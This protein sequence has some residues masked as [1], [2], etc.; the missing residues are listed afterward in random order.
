MSSRQ[1]RRSGMVWTAMLYRRLTFLL[2][3]LALTLPMRPAA[4]RAVVVYVE[5]SDLFR[6]RGR[7][8][9]L[10]R[11]A[12][13][14][15]ASRVYE[16]GLGMAR[17]RGDFRSSLRFLNN[18][19]SASFQLLR[20]R[21]AARTYLQA[22]GIAEAQ[23]D[24]E[25]LAAASF[26]LSSV[27]LQLG[28]VDAAREAAERG[29]GAPAGAASKFQSSLLIQL[30][31]ISAGEGDWSGAA[32]RLHQ[33]IAVARGQADSVAE[34]QAWNELGNVLL[35]CRRLPEAEDA[36]LESYRLR[37]LARDPRLH[38]SYEAL[39]ELRLAQNDPA[40]AARLLDR[41]IEIA[42]DLGPAALWRPLYSR[43]RARRALGRTEEAYDDLRNAVD[44]LRDWR[45]Q[46]LPA[47]AFR[48]RSEAESHR[49]YTAFIDAASERARQT[50]RGLYAREAF[51][52]AESGRAASLRALWTGTDRTRQ[53]SPDYW[54]VRAELRRA[55]SDDARN[56]AGADR[57]RGVRARL[58][59][60]EAEA[61]LSLAPTPEAAGDAGKLIEATRRALG[62]GEA[63]I[64]FHTGESRSAV[65]AV[66]RDTFAMADAPPEAELERSIGEF[67]DALRT[68]KPEARAAG[69]R[70]FAELFGKLGR[71]VLAMQ[72]WTVAPDG[73]LF[74]LPFA[75]L[76]DGD[77]YLIEG[78]ELRVTIG[79]AGLLRAPAA[80]GS[81]SFVGIGDPVYNRADARHPRRSAASAEG[82]SL[83]LPRLPGS[84]REV[85]SCAAL[86]R[87][88]GRPALLIEGADATREKL[89]RALAGRPAVAH[90]AA[91]MLF[92][93][94]GAVRGLLAL[95]LDPRHGVELLSDTEVAGM[96]ANV[97]LV[98]LNGCSS[99]R[100]AVLPGA[101]LMGMTRAW[102]AAGAH[103]VIATRWPA[104]DQ[105]ASSLFESLYRLYFERRER[106]TFGALLREAQL[107]ELR[108]GGRRAEP[109]RWASYFCLE[110]R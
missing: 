66:T 89:A 99:G 65:F 96:D 6:L 62:P 35:E 33:A 103:A 82:A 51:A 67:V 83:E 105:T 8:N 63:Y 11:A 81:D 44:N 20:Y 108:A 49:V 39:A 77:R 97:G 13:Y 21:D 98:V 55:E 18:L 86:W 60:M 52:A 34:A 80:E 84:G 53:L 70:L 30:A 87:E 1:A 24:G 76:T 23:G 95:S 50:G 32:G 94:R 40:S 58:A 93:G 7:G 88:Q 104:P 68:G 107:A 110:T 59:E 37:K 38:Y 91:H 47:D 79:V 31:L 61:G 92:P 56:D 85:E 2:L 9:E 48:V 26:N 36:L 73:P 71:R 17:Q 78:R 57:A 100:G 69:G 43:G 106:G 5:P 75:A 109:A 14:A 102:L 19:G 42:T 27:Y 25:M 46:V 72:R 10:F 3:L 12:D 41:A 90:V 16:T 28:E 22:R 29:V 45:A 74:D 15:G 101:G 64:G 4:R 54:R